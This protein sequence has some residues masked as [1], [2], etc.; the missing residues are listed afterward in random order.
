MDTDLYHVEIHFQRFTEWLWRVCIGLWLWDSE[1]WRIK[2]DFL[3][4]HA[5]LCISFFSSL[6]T[7]FLQ[8]CV[9][10]QLFFLATLLSKE[11]WNIICNMKKAIKFQYIAPLRLQKPFF[12][13]MK[14]ETEKTEIQKFPFLVCNHNIWK[15]L[16]RSD[17]SWYDYLFNCLFTFFQECQLFVYISSRNFNCCFWGENSIFK[18]CVI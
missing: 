9:C 10:C 5:V 3:V 17:M 12:C 13:T 15:W 8:D 4:E 7:F 2:R 16:V 11:H 6:S 1:W 18:H 14:K